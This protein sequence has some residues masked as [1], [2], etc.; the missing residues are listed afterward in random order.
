MYIHNS[1]CQGKIILDLSPMV[2]FFANIVITQQGIRNGTGN[3]SLDKDVSKLK[4]YCLV[5]K[6]HV[7]IKDILAFCLYCGKTYLLPEI[8]Y[9]ST[10]GPQYCLNCANENFPDERKF[11]LDKIFSK[12]K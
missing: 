7:D 12:I 3:I 9:L 4:Y 5:C 6:Q 2:E 11:S 8:F 10:S 1:N